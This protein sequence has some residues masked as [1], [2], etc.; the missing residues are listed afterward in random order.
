MLRR[1][2]GDPAQDYK[3][4]KYAGEDGGSISAPSDGG[5][6]RF[7]AGLGQLHL[8]KDQADSGKPELLESDWE[9][10]QRENSERRG[11][12][13]ALGLSTNFTSDYKFAVSMS[14]IQANLQAA[15]DRDEQR[16]LQ[17]AGLGFAGRPYARPRNSLKPSVDFW[18]EGQ[19]SSYE[20]GTGGLNR[21][22]R[23]GILHLGADVPLTKNVLLGA[24]VQF[25]WTD[26]KLADP[27]IAGKVQGNG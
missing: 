21:N 12:F 10:L 13:S 26:E 3:P 27:D 11:V 1:L 18:A 24:V 19:V 15:E 8:G 23:F 6:L 20:D 25:D 2:E 14:E 5:R 16:K 4:L 17:H 9:R 7:G 22:G